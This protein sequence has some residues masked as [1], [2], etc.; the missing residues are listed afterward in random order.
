VCA[1]D[2]DGLYYSDGQTDAKSAAQKREQ[3]TFGERLSEKLYP[4]CSKG[5]PHRIFLLP[6][7]AARQLQAGDIC[8]RDKKYE[9]Y[10][11]S[12]RQQNWPRDAI[13]LRSQGLCL[14]RETFEIGIRLS[15]PG[16]YC[17]QL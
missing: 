2:L 12:Q 16:S 14:D 7:Q 9:R 15:A 13:Q 3:Q 6:L 1:E 11:S 10:S 5:A 8:A 17:P 4:L